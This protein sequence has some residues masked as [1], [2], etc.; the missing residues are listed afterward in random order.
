VTQALS[1]KQVAAELSI[2]VSTARQHMLTMPGVFR[3]GRAVRIGRLDFERWIQRRKDDAAWARD[4]KPSP[5]RGFATSS[6]GMRFRLTEP[7]RKKPPESDNVARLSR[8]IVPRTR[9]RPDL[10]PGS[11]GTPPHHTTARTKPK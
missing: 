4:A 2:P 11:S 3:V 6:G 7:R 9:P 1:P 10:L 8:P 5:E